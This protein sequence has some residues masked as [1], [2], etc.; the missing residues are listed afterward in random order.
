MMKMK[1]VLFPLLIMMGV[2]SVPTMWALSG[3]ERA[4]IKLEIDKAF[5]AN[6]FS[7]VKQLIEVLR[8]GGEERIADE[9]E[10]KLNNKV[11]VLLDN[12][13]KSVNDVWNALNGVIAARNVPDADPGAGNADGQRKWRAK[14]EL[15]RLGQ[16]LHL[17][18]QIVLENLH[19]PGAQDP[20]ILDLLAPV[21]QTATKVR[22]LYV[23]LAP[24][25]TKG[26]ERRV[27]QEMDAIYNQRVAIQAIKNS[28]GAAFVHND[29]GLLGAVE[30]VD[31]AIRRAKAAR[32][33]ESL[34]VVDTAIRAAKEAIVAG[35]GIQP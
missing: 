19:K 6:K 15:K 30:A 17:Q 34:I 4:R 22:D 21:V 35:G 16:Q 27:N 31:L 25:I 9:F 33:L 26:N 1:N 24:S 3:A 14:N 2:G 20:L 8:R 5:T 29:T 18:M 12:L 11:Y 32:T 28:L 23:Y 7:Q 13:G 10:L